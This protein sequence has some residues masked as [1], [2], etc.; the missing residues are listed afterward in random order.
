[1]VTR[2]ARLLDGDP[3]LITLPQA[4]AWLGI[5]AKTAQR[6]AAA[7][8]FPGDAAIQIGR[9]WKVSLQKL[10]RHLHGTGA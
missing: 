2:P 3:D 5:S 8:T 4:A 10:R 9:T 7:G 6:M 1:M